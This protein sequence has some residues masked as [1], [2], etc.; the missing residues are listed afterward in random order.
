MRLGLILLMALAPLGC[1]DAEGPEA[2]YLEVDSLLR[3]HVASMDEGP[4]VTMAYPYA[5]TVWKDSLA[6]ADMRASGVHILS[7][8][9]EGGRT[10][11]RRGEGPGEFRMPQGIAARADTLVVFDRGNRRLTW[12]DSDGSFVRQIGV[13]LVGVQPRFALLPSGGVVAPTASSE[14][15]V[16]VLEAD[17]AHLEIARTHDAPPLDES[18][19]TS[20]LVVQSDGGPIV[21]DAENGL[22]IFSEG[23]A[24]R[25]PGSVAGEVSARVESLRDPAGERRVVPIIAA[26][27][28]PEGIVVWFVGDGDLGGGIVT[29]RG[30]WTWIH[31][32]SAVTV[33]E[34]PSDVMIW[35]EELLVLT[36]DGVRV[37]RL[38]LRDP[39]DA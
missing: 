21:V 38:G 16:E 22:V 37:F 12:L 18:P 1:V 30:E 9:L 7:R 19:F 34:N 6:V 11:E 23:D 17:S 27:P 15:Y 25:L 24:I 2:T 3:S 14:Y 29:P 32:G 39:I 10:I 26:G 4:G 31:R 13:M 5:M 28:A 33:P 20:N 36:G 35:G 8:S